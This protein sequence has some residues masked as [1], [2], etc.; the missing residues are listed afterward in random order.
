MRRRV[1]ERGAHAVQEAPARET[2]E[3]GKRAG[4][5]KRERHEGLVDGRS[6][7]GGGGARREQGGDLLPR[8]AGARRLCRYLQEMRARRGELGRD[9]GRGQGEN[10]ADGGGGRCSL[11]ELRGHRSRDGVDARSPRGHDD[12][13][14]EGHSRKEDELPGG[15]EDRLE[16]TLEGGEDSANEAVGRGGRA[17]KSAEAQAEMRD[18]DFG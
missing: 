15:G 4:P 5:G 11:R 13:E 14:I 8:P 17:A 18:R 3:K 6:C 12:P 10:L 2:S 9:G 1:V 16:L 7:L